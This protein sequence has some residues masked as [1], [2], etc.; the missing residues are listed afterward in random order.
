[1]GG[2]MAR[3]SFADLCGQPLGA[4]DYLALC[5][6]FHTF[7]IDDIPQLSAERHNEARRF[8]TLIDTFYDQKRRLIVSA[9]VEPDRLYTQ[10]PGA[11]E[12]DRTASRLTEMRQS[13]W[14]DE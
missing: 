2:G 13:D 8:I 3:F 12:F 1:M 4:H 6:H 5:E 10:G 14:P 7:F 9:M 11:R